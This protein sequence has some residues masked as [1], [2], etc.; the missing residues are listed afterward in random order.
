MRELSKHLRYFT[1]LTLI[2][3]TANV[4][5]LANSV[6]Q[7]NA[8]EE[9][10]SLQSMMDSD[11]YDKVLTRSQS[12]LLNAGQKNDLYLIASYYA[13]IASYH[14][15]NYLQSSRYLLNYKSNEGISSLDELA[16]LYWGLNLVQ[17]GYKL[18]AIHGLRKFEK[19]YKDSFFI[20][21]PF[22]TLLL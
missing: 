12:I 20:L 4:E 17:L 19:K 6:T 13:G 18:P 22:I 10:K 9:L 8:S 5:N 15:K 7:H 14:K 1:C 3:Y 21:K 2:F 16:N 11:E